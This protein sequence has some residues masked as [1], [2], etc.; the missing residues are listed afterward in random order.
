M[1]A[2]LVAALGLLLLACGSDATPASALTDTLKYTRSGGIAGVN[3]GATVK[4]DGHATLGDKRKGQRKARLTA[5]ERARLTRLVRAAD[6][7]HVKVD[8]R[9]ECCDQFEY[10]LSYRGRTLHWSDAH[11]PKALSPLT[12]ELERLIGKYGGGPG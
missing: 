5:A 8:S 7:A 11:F 4:P 3:V 9:T 10:S 2:L 1:K 12:G 6:L